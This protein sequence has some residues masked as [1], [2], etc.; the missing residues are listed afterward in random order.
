[1]RSVDS[2]RG[3]VNDKNGV[4]FV[5]FQVNVFLDIEILEAI[6]QSWKVD[7]FQVHLWIFR[8]DENG[9]FTDII[10]VIQVFASILQFFQGIKFKNFPSCAN[11][12]ESLADL[13]FKLCAI[14]KIDSP[15]DSSSPLLVGYEHIPP[16]KFVKHSA[17]TG[18]SDSHNHEL[19]EVFYPVFSYFPDFFEVIF[20]KIFS[21]FQLLLIVY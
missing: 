6:I 20:E 5:F 4:S 9:N 3:E 17:F 21:I 14:M 19:V 13:K 12:L 1:M 15:S 2:A 16:N 10:N 18:F 7:K 11:M 8:W